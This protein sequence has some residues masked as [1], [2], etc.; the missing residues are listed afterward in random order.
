MQLVRHTRSTNNNFPRSIKPLSIPMLLAACS[1]GACLLPPSTARAQ[2]SF[3]SVELVSGTSHDGQTSPMVG[4]PFAL[5][6]WSPETRN[7][8]KKCVAPYYY[9]DDKITGFRGTHWLSGSCAM[10]YGSFTLMP[11]TGKISAGVAAHASGFKHDSEKMDPAYYAVT[12]DR[13]SERVEL[14]GSVRSGMMRITFPAGVAGSVLVQPNSLPKEGF[15]EVHAAAREIVGYNPVHRSYRGQGKLAGFNGYF[16]ARFSEPFTTQGTWC[17][18]A[19]G[20]KLTQHEACDGLGGYAT[21]APLSKP[22]QIKIGTSF[23]SLEEAAKNLDAEQTGFDFDAVRGKTEAVWKKRLAQIE[24]EGGT[25][26]QRKVFY[27]AVY[28]EALAPR[29]VNDADGTYNGFANEGKLHHI[30]GDYYDDY[31]MW[32]TFRALHP[33]FTIIDPDRQQAMVRSLI[34]KGQQGGWMPIFPLFNSYTSAMIG[35]HT[36]AV[37]ADAMVKGLTD[38]DGKEAF[39]LLYKN[40]TQ[41]PPQDQYVDGKGRRALPSYLKYGYVPLEDLVPDAFHRQEQ[42]TRTLEYALDD[43]MVATLAKRY[44]TPEQVA[45]M[46]KRSENWRNT[47]DPQTGFARGRHADGTW[48]VPF[49]PAAQHM[50]YITEGVPWQYTFLVPQ[51]L[52]GLIDYVGGREKFVAKLDGLFANGLYDQGNEPSHHIA[53]LYDYAGA[54]PRTQ[55]ALRKIMAEYKP[56]PSGLPGNDDAGQMSAWYIFSAMG[57]YPVTP[58]TPFYTIGAPLFSKATIH[59]P[60]GKDFVI[61]AKNQSPANMYIQSQKLNGQPFPHFLLPH[62]DIAK[63][64]KLVFEMGPAPG[65]KQFE[66]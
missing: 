41:T 39:R 48:V 11:V 64:G 4:M 44:G 53:Y 60:N 56:G 54:A 40:A 9:G 28:H 15:V 31:S 47:I 27:T 20:D 22:L 66:K 58:G 8:E 37:I 65:K 46:Q 49:D 24:V 61:E 3:T 38:F 19:V 29:I 59:L 33:M 7:T 57:F 13:Y 36:S 35:D 10:E 52:P 30:D 25:P 62:A 63:G 2:E 6:Q 21:F 18:S 16:V 45:E 34:L 23:T 26:Q 32:D 42:V 12:L 43:A 51:N 17:G 5:T 55:A 1:L 50:K 14:T